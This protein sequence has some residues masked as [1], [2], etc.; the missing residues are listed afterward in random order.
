MAL[1]SLWD[2][3]LVQGSSSTSVVNPRN[4]ETSWKAPSSFEA[5]GEGGSGVFAQ[6]WLHQKTPEFLRQGYLSSLGNAFAGQDSWSS[7]GLL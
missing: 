5:G 6:A 4:P 7:T 1:P 3:P 2:H